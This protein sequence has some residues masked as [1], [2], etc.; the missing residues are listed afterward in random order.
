MRAA[1]A[2]KRRAEWSSEIKARFLENIV[3]T[4]FVVRLKRRLPIR[5][6]GRPATSDSADNGGMGRGLVFAAFILSMSTALYPICPITIIEFCLWNTLWS[7][8]QRAG[9]RGGGCR[10]K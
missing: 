9:S 7:L 2:R 8:S 4:G 5:E 1:R 3:G 10:H 6:C